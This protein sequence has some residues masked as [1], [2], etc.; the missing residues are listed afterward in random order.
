MNP[1]LFTDSILFKTVEVQALT[2]QITWINGRLWCIR[3][4]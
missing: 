4:Q 1:N 2:Y 3:D